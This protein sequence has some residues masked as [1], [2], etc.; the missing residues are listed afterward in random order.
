[1]TSRRMRLRKPATEVVLALVSL[2]FRK[3]AANTVETGLSDRP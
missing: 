2:F 1:M 3:P